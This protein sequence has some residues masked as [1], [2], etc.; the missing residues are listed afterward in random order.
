MHLVHVSM[1]ISIKCKEDKITNFF[2]YGK[3]K[4]LEKPSYAQTQPHPGKLNPSSIGGPVV[5]GL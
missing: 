3:S 2:Q 1:E 4:Q 5:E